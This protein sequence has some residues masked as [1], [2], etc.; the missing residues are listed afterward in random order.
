VTVAAEAGR[1]DGGRTGRIAVLA[2]LAATLGP[3]GRLIER[4]AAAASADV[5]VTA[6]VVEGAVAARDAGDRATHD[7]LI[8]EAVRR[9]DADVLVLAQASMAAAAVDAGAAVPVLTSPEG[10]VAALAEALGAAGA[11]P[12]STT[13]AAS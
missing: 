1:A 13:S 7:R 9:V 10:G 2:T 3:T 6:A 4:A 5:V 8:R 12:G 11:Q